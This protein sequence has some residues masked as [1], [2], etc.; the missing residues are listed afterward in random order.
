MSTNSVYPQELTEMSRDSDLEVQK[1]QG[2]QLLQAVIIPLFGKR[3]S[4]A[5][6]YWHRLR[7]ADV[8]LELVDNNP[9][10]DVRLRAIA[11]SYSHHANLGGIAGALNAGVARLR[12]ETDVAVVTFLD[13]D[14][15][16]SPAG[17]HRLASRV[18]ENGSPPRVV[19]PQIWDGQRQRPHPPLLLSCRGERFPLLIS[20][21]TTFRLDDWD[22]LG[23]LPEH[24]VVDY[25]DTLWCC[26]VLARGFA[27]EQCSQAVL[28]Q[29][30][31]QPHPN[32][33]CRWLGMQLYSPQRHYYALRNLRWLWRSAEVPRSLKW[34]EG[35]RMLVKPWLW[36][37]LE[38]HRADN[39]GAIVRGVW[40]WF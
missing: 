17:L 38:P 27:L 23:S 30:F 16:I 18:E 37:L 35:L 2:S 28:V 33:L 21:G 6:A 20:S 39:F 32:R 36:L 9:Q 5:E 40:S 24:L 19:G 7:K 29:C 14:S 3:D 10:P 12:A 4:T 22:A 13:Q 31:G 34:R 11:S 1:S 25:V 15:R 26:R 8:W